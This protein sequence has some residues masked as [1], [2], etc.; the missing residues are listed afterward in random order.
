MTMNAAKDNDFRQLCD[1]IGFVCVAVDPDVNITF[2]NQE[3]ARQFGRP[4]HDMIGQCFLDVIPEP[5]RADAHQVF[6]AALRDA[7]PGEMEVKYASAAHRKQTFVLIVSPIVDSEGR[8][9]GA[10]AAMR[11]IS[12]RQRLSRELA[13]ARRM[14]SLGRMAGAVAHH[15]NNIL[16]GMMAGVD[17]A[18]ASDS[19]RD[20]RRTLRALAQSIGRATRI[21]Q[22]L[23]AFA[24]SENA[25]VEQSELGP[26]IERFVT[27]TQRKARKE[28]IE[29]RTHIDA[30]P[31]GQFDAN[32]VLSVLESIAQNGFDAM[33]GG[34]TLTVELSHDEDDAFIR[35]IDTGRGIPDDELEHIFDPFFTTKGQLT[36]QEGDN[37]GLG[38]AAVHGLVAE[39]GGSISV[40]SIVGRGTQV[41][42]RLPLDRQR[43]GAKSATA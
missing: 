17:S 35:V 24:E 18:L 21:T 10:S 1:H 40:S 16:G 7:V 13:R 19:Q 22:Q 2:W 14:G 34:G 32:R 6:K 27:N 11:D 4:A 39:M 25:Q 23:A 15:F 12:E 9:I 29:F 8:C 3:A 31:T 5:D 26:V 30:V 43:D 28:G 36:S 38:L 33:K 20:T 42:I 41:Q 37:I